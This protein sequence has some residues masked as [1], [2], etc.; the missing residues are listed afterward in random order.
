MTEEQKNAARMVLGYFGAEGGYEPGGFTS[1]ILR[2]YQKADPGNRARLRLGFPELA[3]MMDACMNT[4]SG[5]ADL[6]K[7]VAA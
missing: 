3:D 4:E 1:L 7:A 5:V 6:Q 2:A